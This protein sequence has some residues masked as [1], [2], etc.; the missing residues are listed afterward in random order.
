M[1]CYCSIVIT[2]LISPI[3]KCFTANLT[4]TLTLT[5]PEAKPISIGG[6]ADEEGAGFGSRLEQLWP[7]SADDEGGGAWL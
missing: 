3:T 2:H 1:Y 7:P 6:D 4:L 5:I